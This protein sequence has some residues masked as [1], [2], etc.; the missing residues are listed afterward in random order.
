MSR[1]PPPLLM[2]SKQ[3]NLQ[4][5]LWKESLVVFNALS[6][7][8]EKAIT[9]PGSVT[10]EQLH[11]LWRKWLTARSVHDRYYGE[12]V[13]ILFKKQPTQPQP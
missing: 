2:T 3:T 11:E 7:E 6:Q 1:H 13:D 10:Q 4:W 8:L 5:M 12:L 9:T